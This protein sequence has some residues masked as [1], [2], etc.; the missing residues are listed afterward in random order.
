MTSVAHICV[1]ESEFL[2]SEPHSILAPAMSGL[3]AGAASV[4]STLPIHD[5]NEMLLAELG[6]LKRPRRNFLAAVF[7][8]DPF[9]TADSLLKAVSIA[10]ITQIVN[11]PSVAFMGPKIERDLALH[12]FGYE[13]EVEFARY[14]VKLGWSVTGTVMNAQQAE[15]MLGVGCIDLLFHPPLGK[16][17]AGFRD[18]SVLSAFGEVQAIA[19]ANGSRASLYAE[20]NEAAALPPSLPFRVVVYHDRPKRRQQ[21]A[22]K[23]VLPSCQPRSPVASS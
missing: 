20:L 3:P 12:G 13:K 11:W 5:A 23:A 10:G 14:A 7:A 15:M 6:R 1:D 2:S 22:S 4:L 9:R 8:V 17:S 18:G 16:V 19:Q 21:K